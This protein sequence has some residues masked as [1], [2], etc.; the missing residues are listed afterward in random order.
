MHYFEMT[1]EHHVWERRL[2]NRTPFLE[3]SGKPPTRQ[4]GERVGQVPQKEHMALCRRTERRLP[5]SVALGDH[6]FDA[7]IGV[8]QFCVTAMYGVGCQSHLE[9][10]AHTLTPRHLAAAGSA[11]FLIIQIAANEQARVRAYVW[12]RPGNDT[13]RCAARVAGRRLPRRFPGER[14]LTWR[15]GDVP[16][17]QFQTTDK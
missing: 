3:S 2:T 12:T 11:G 5:W 6:E 1:R 9:K 4:T 17:R 14:R 16:C 7:A 15:V 13:L 10:Y 8:G